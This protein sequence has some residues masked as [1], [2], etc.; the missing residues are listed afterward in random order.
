[1]EQAFI[2]Q[3]QAITLNTPPAPDLLK[4]VFS[5]CIDMKHTDKATSIPVWGGEM[6][7]IPGNSNRVVWQ[8]TGTVLINTWVQPAY[9]R[10]GEIE[11]ASWVFAAFF[12]WLFPRDVERNR[13][14]DWLAWSLQNEDKKPAWALLLYSREK[15]TG[16]STFCDIACRL[17]GAENTT[18]QN[19]VGK[20]TN[21][22]NAVALTSRLVISEEVHLSPESA[23]SNTLKTYIT[24]TQTLVE[25]KGREPDRINLVLSFIFT[26][27]H[28]PVRIEAG[29]RRYYVVDTGHAG[30]SAGEKGAEF[31]T[32]IGHVKEAMQDPVA[33]ARLYS[34]LMICQL[35]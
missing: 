29:E 35:S 12:N 2:N 23:S 1:M 34:E 27:N 32:L 18:T 6:S 26:T 20:L 7:C 30:H 25:R 14:L 4:R 24:D 28:M 17:F 22:F 3:V 33:I 10:L 5:H 11:P 8:P 16:K 15:G 31:A 19:N 9:R 13:V 21:R